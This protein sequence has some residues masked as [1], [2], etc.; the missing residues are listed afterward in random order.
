M[1]PH[2]K[3]KVFRKTNFFKCDYEIVTCDR[4]SYVPATKIFTGYID[5]IAIAYI[6]NCTGY[7]IISVGKF[8]L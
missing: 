3:V 7:V 5:E 8:D 6:S 2:M 4:V 1:K